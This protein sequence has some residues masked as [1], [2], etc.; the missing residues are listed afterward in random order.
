MRAPT[1]PRLTT[2][3]NQ[4][5]ADATKATPIL[6]QVSHKEVFKPEDME[7]TPP[8]VHTDGVECHTLPAS[9]G[10]AHA[11]HALTGTA[12]SDNA[13]PEDIGSSKRK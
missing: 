11:A 4:N 8:P 7:F 6:C 1:D 2:N 9:A 5:I 3:L 10:A 12:A 13:T